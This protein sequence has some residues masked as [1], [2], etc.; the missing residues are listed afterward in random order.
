M[1]ITSIIIGLV[2]GGIA[3]WVIATLTLKKGAQKSI[4]E[5]NR[6]ADLII[7]EARLTAKR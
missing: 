7:Q 4:E 1:D 2:V 5:H 6:Q 3:T